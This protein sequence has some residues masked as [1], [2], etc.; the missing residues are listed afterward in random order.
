MCDIESLW[1]YLKQIIFE[2]IHL[3]TPRVSSRS[4]ERPKWFTSNL[5]HKL[6]CVHSLRRKQ[7]KKPSANLQIKL[8]DAELSLQK[9]MIAAKAAFESSLI[10]IILLPPIARVNNREG[11]V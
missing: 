1:S 7:S 3:F 6:N 4:H 8:A 9:D 2:A 11:S 10:H 5:R